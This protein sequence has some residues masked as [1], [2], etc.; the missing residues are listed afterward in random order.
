MCQ[1]SSYTPNI[2]LVCVCGG[3]KGLVDFHWRVNR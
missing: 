1:K 3:G 2:S